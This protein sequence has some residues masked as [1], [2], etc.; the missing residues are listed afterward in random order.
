MLRFIGR[1][2]S[3]P[4]ALKLGSLIGRLIYTLAPRRRQIARI[5]LEL[6][7][8]EHSPQENDAFLLS[9]FEALGIGLI[10]TAMAWWSS[11]DK[12]RPLVHFEGLEH[13]DRALDEGRGIILLGS[14]FTDLE[15]SGR[16][17]M[18]HRTSAVMYRPHENP[19]IDRC[20]QEHRH[21]VFQAAIQRDDIRQTVRELKKNHSV[22]YAPDQSFKGR[23][24]TLAEFFGIP[25]ATN[26]GTSR[27]AKISKAPVMMFACYRL[28]GTAGFKLIIK[29]PLENF[30]SDDLQADATRI[31]HEVEQAV[32][33]AP[34]QYL[35]IHRR[36]KKRK[37]LPDLY[38]SVDR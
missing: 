34:E 25:A 31:N 33:L 35:W 30:P 27:L 37:G 9:H 11:D 19:V 3:Y 7:F 28:P 24:S 5:N 18:L 20:F 6:C 14:H 1:H 15:L 16:L 29:P 36:F 17:F 10:T 38:E 8:P 23:N 32:R 12:L 21:S 22:W 4:A 2:I 26:T 13:F